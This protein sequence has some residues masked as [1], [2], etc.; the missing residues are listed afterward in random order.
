MTLARDKL[1]AAV[2]P[3]LPGLP[4]PARV[5]GTLSRWLVRVGDEVDQ[6]A[7]LA[8]YLDDQGALLSLSAPVPGAVLAL[9]LAPGGA[10]APGAALCYL[11]SAVPAAPSPL[12][13]RSRVAAAPSPLPAV[14]LVE[15]EHVLPSAA[16]SP[17]RPGSRRSTL[18]VAVDEHDAI[19]ELAFDPPSPVRQPVTT[20]KPKLKKRTF[21]VRTDQLDAIRRIALRYRDD[22]GFSQMEV[23]RAALAD[24][25]ALA[26]D[27]Q[28]RRLHLYRQQETK[29]ELGASARH[30]A[31]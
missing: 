8:E 31:E 25:L 10:F 7:P 12:P 24:F 30:R 11:Q 21:L 6:F 22:E 3:A 5:S 1:L 4:V 18:G 26:P 28:E 20:E 19:E 27:E 15:L 13:A 2:A 9:S 14:E 16:L 23:T 29:L 17:A